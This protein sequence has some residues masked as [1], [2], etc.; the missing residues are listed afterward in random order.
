MENGSRPNQRGH[1]LWYEI[2]WER[3][4]SLTEEIQNSWMA[5]HPVQSL[6]DVATDLKALMSSLR[7]WSKEKF[8]AV[9]RG[10]DKIRKRIEEL[11]GGD[12]GA[13]SDEIRELRSRMDELLYREEMMWL[14]RSRIA[15]LKE[16]DRNTKYFHRKAARRAKKNTIKFLKKSD[17]QLTKDRKEMENMATVFFKELY[18]AEEHVNPKP[19]TGLFEEIIMEEMNGDLCKEFTGEEISDALFQIGPLKAPGP[20]G[21]PA[22]FFQR[23]WL[24]LKADVT[25]A[26]WGFLS[27]EE[28]LMGSMKRLL[29]YYLRRRH[30][31][32]QKT[33]G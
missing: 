4:A 15:W 21:F 6:A 9:T 22:H 19:L 16:G 33:L 10:L 20:D 25:R 7:R 13:G 24:T 28:C 32:I 23:N 3:E 14:Q 5:G 18:T 31:T 26:V 17:G 30:Q 8:G 27:L 29:S 11:G 12:L 2:M 1:I